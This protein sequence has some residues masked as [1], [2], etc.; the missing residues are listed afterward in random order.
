MTGISLTAAKSDVAILMP[1]FVAK[2]EFRA[3]LQNELTKLQAHSRE[4]HGCVDYS[5]FV[6]A[7]DLDRFILY[8][9]W[10]T[11]EALHAHNEQEHVKNFLDVVPDWL[12]RPLEVT[13][14]RTVGNG[15][16]EGP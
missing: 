1:V 7:N 15:A 2:P 13:R 16:P 5:V 8:E 12:V 3:A 4:D 14:L 9:E 11:E 6:D 10:S